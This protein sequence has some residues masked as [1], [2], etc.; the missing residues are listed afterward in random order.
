MEEQPGRQ[1]ATYTHVF[2][3]APERPPDRQQAHITFCFS[4]RRC[5]KYSASRRLWH[6]GVTPISVTHWPTENEKSGQV[7]QPSVQGWIRDICQTLTDQHK[8]H[9]T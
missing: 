4:R 8:R 1:G 2:P 7:E 6:I 3:S 5:V 9:C